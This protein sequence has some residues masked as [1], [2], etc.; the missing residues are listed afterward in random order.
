V[1]EIFRKENPMGLPESY[2]QELSWDPNGTLRPTST[3]QGRGI[4]SE[5]PEGNTVQ[6][7]SGTVVQFIRM[8]IRELAENDVRCVG[9]RV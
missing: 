7:V 2:Y 5:H 8:A 9:E 1:A 3:S 6:C 4:P